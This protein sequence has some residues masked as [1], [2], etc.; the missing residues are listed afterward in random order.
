MGQEIPN[1]K[2]KVSKSTHMHG[3]PEDVRD[4]LLV[5]LGVPPLQA[6]HHVRHGTPGA[7][8]GG[9]KGGILMYY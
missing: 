2:S 4:L 7:E 5:K 9:G 6:V 1:Y 3:L 8:L